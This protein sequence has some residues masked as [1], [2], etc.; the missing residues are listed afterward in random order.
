M[1]SKGPNNKKNKNFMLIFEINYIV[2]IVSKNYFSNEA[3]EIDSLVVNK[4]ILNLLLKS[5]CNSH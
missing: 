1:N 4:G 2:V 5:F 3:T